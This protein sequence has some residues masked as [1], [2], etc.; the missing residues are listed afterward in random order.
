MAKSK[1][2]VRY[3]RPVHI[4]IG[5]V[6]F[7]IICFYMMFYVYSYF[8]SAHISVYEVVPGSIAVNNTYTGLAL[9]KEE[10]ITSAYAGQI[11]Y[12]IKDASRAGANS[13][14]Y[15]VDEDGA[16]A[17]QINAAREDVS[18]LDEESL[19]KIQNKVSE[20]SGGYRPEA[21]YEVYSMKSDL[22]AE[23]AEVTSIGALSS[24]IDAISAA[25]NTTFHME[26][27]GKAGVVV[28]Y[29]DG[30]ESV[31]PKDVTEEM[32]DETAYQKMNL[33]EKASI[34]AG[35]PACKL[36]TDEDWHIVIPARNDTIKQLADAKTVRIK[37]KKDD[38]VVRATVNIQEKDGM[39][40]IVL[41]LENS[42][43]RFAADRFIEVEL[44]LTEEQGLKIPNSAITKKD[45]FT[46]PMTYFQKGDNSNTEGVMIRRTDKNGEHTDTFAAQTIYM[47]TE[48]DYYVESE[49]LKD[50][51]VILKPN[52]KETYTVHKTA[53]LDGIYC[54]NKGY[55]VFRDIDV[56]YQNE[57]YSIIR[58]GTKYGVN[59][60]DHIA[61]DGSSIAENA[62]IHD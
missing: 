26:R 51:D 4:N 13:I 2:V 30:F 22:N 47:S 40:L 15:S 35:E 59:M 10:V 3:R 29:T 55:A 42:M 5:L 6:V 46:V 52:S 37:F 24:I 48:Y 17:K 33:K 56:I 53:S 14:V 54:I 36:I 45:F 28:Y 50:G 43:V 39:S 62:L 32:F 41:G 25:Q 9:R 61:L 44:L 60:Y 20:Y 58:S 27:A 16:I 34:N 11:N 12:Y 8:T 31:R 23:L 49:N 1:K 21:F 7:G 19:D 18:S 57:E 38:T